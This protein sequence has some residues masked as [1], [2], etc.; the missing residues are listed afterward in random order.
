[1]LRQDRV[2]SVTPSLSENPFL[3]LFLFLQ[4]IMYLRILAWWVRVTR[5]YARMP[6]SVTASHARMALASQFAPVHL[7][8]VQPPKRLAFWSA[9]PT[10]N[11]DTRS[12]MK[13]STFRP[14]RCGKGM[15]TTSSSK[16]VMIAKKFRTMC[17]D[18]CILLRLATRYDLKRGW[19]L[20][21]FLLPTLWHK[22][23]KKL[24]AS[25]I[26]VARLDGNKLS[27]HG[28]NYR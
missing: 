9:R 18:P 11:V 6:T 24:V 23:P 17:G 12:S 4:I 26:T 20:G 16:E 13:G 7:S 1:M 22:S 28:N 3:T 8:T 21:T 2:R 27:F 19:S 15:E 25:Y 14:C 10:I 5:H